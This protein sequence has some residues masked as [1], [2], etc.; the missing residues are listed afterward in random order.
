MLSVERGA[1]I[2]MTSTFNHRFGAFKRTPMSNL[3]P[4]H[5]DLITLGMDLSNS[6]F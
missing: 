4:R 3:T 5:S 6:V 1:V 2:S